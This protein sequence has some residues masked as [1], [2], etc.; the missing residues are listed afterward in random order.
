M[1]VR[2]GRWIGTALVFFQVGH[3]ITIRILI[4][5]IGKRIEPIIDFPGIGHSI[6]VIVRI[7]II[8]DSVTVIVRPF[9]GIVREEIQHI[10]HLVIVPIGTRRL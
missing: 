8:A 3:A 7:L 2:D 4:G 6:V 5:I 10:R 1:V 9:G